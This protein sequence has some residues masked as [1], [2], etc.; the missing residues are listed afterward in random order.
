MDSFSSMD[1]FGG[2]G[3]SRDRSIN[4]DTIIE[5]MNMLKNQ[6]AI[7]HQEVL[8]QSLNEKCFKMCVST[9]GSSLDNSQQ[10]CLA[11]CTDRYI[12]AWNSVSRA[13]TNTIRQQHEM[14]RN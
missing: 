10:K 4:R 3:G 14:M 13:L 6:I 7:Q 2:S 9:P 12:E 11:K 5:S 8:L 1:G